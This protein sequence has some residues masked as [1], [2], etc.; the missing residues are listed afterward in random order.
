MDKKLLCGVTRPDTIIQPVFFDGPLF[1]W[2][3]LR[4][5]QCIFNCLLNVSCKKQNKNIFLKYLGGGAQ[6]AVLW[7]WVV[8]LY[9]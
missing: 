1:L 9:W 8:F 2:I 3:A 7:S 5:F 6:M 4:Q